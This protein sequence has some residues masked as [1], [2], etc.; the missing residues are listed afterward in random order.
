M[1][2]LLYAAYALGFALLRPKSA[3]PIN[4][5]TDEHYDLLADYGRSVGRAAGAIAIPTLAF[6]GIWVSAALGLSGSQ[7]PRRIRRVLQL[8]G[9]ARR[10]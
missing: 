9:H 8:S 4:Q 6:I 7:Q 3:P 1:L 5:N 10:N 2:A